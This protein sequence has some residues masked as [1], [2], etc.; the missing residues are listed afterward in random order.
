MTSMA[1]HRHLWEDPSGWL[2]TASYGLP[3]RPAWEA[4]QE[5][6]ADWRV[7]GDHWRSWDRSTDVARHAFAR[8]VGASTGDDAVGSTVAAALAPVAAALPEG[9]TVLVDRVEFT[10]NVFPWQVH[11]DRGVRVVASATEELVDAIRPGVDVVE[12]SAVQSATGTVLDLPS[13]VAASAAVGARV[14]LDASQAAGWL[15]LDVTGVDVLVAHGYKFLMCPRG[16]TFCYLSP[17]LREGMRPLHASWYAAEDVAGSFYGTRM[18]LARSARRFDQSPAWFSF[19]AAAPTL[20]LIEHIGVASIHEHDVA[21][22]N[23]FRAGLGMPASSSAIVTARIPGAAA[24]LAEAGIRAA[25]RDDVLRAAFHLY[26]TDA[27]V[28][29]A[30]HAVLPLMPGPK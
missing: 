30:L 18:E 21:L 8:L 7:G 4:L 13:V 10:S 24:A 6:L 16:A 11:T 12:V 25:F 17:R 2:D 22:A 27:D 28:D 26:S 23:R 1:E 9:T 15:P 19:V 29:R 20:E 3:P 5:A 14:V